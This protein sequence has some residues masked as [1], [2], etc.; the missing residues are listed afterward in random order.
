[1]ADKNQLRKL[2]FRTA[3]A[4]SMGGLLSGFMTA[5]I[6][7]VLPLIRDEWNLS[8]NQQ[9]W[10]TS[11]ALLGA[12]LGAF[13][14]SRLTVPFGRKNIV[15]L[16]AILFFT[17][18]ISCFISHDILMLIMSRALVG[19]AIG[20]SSFSL[21]LYITE[22][23]PSRNHSSLIT[24]NQLMITI[25]IL[26]AYV[27]SLLLLPFEHNWRW[28]MLIGIIPSALLFFSMTILPKT[29]KY[30]IH[31][32]RFMQARSSLSRIE[33]PE[34]IEMIMDIMKNEIESEKYYQT[35]WRDIFHR[36]YLRVL[37]ISISIMFVQQCTGINI[38]IYFSPIIFEISGFHSINAEIAATVAIGIINVLFTIIS[39]N[40]VENFARKPLYFTGLIGM[41][42]ML[43]T[44]GFSFLFYNDLGSYLKWIVF[45]CSIGFVM[46][47]SVSMG[48]IGWLMSSEVLPNRSRNVGMSITILFN[49]LF[50]FLI[51]FSFFKISKTFAPAGHEFIIQESNKGIVDIFFNPAVNF[52]L[53]GLFGIAGILL[54]YYVLP[55]TKGMSYLDID[56]YWNTRFENKK[57]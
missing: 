29:P 15:L 14:A 51:I 53:Y 19:I 54:G 10:M 24:L 20:L 52:L 16:S 45:G 30:L 28:M 6:A 21:P 46:F 12:V 9:E 18:T 22:I 44:L 56:D 13:A 32:G 34:K 48:P 55:E 47:F 5:V 11:V 39:I 2:L 27:N 33:E 50:N 36:K 42:V 31:K 37:M 25:G 3:L 43:M 41:T 17:G 38:F 7:G 1:M 49:W 57:R 8:S 40:L 4:S 26:F 23:S 35:R